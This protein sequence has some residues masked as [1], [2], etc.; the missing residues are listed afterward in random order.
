[1]LDQ[2]NALFDRSSKIGKL[3]K[4]VYDLLKEHEAAGEDGLPTSARFL[5]YELVVKQVLAKHGTQQGARRA[6]Q[7]LH[8]ALTD[9]REHGLV[10]WDWIVD[11]TRSL[12][13]HTGWSSIKAA[14]LSSAR[15]AR[16]DPWQ[17]RY[18]LVLCESRSLAGVL[19]KLA[20]RYCVRIAATNGQVGGFL[21][22]DIAP[23]L[24]PGDRVL[25]I[26]DWD[27]QGHQIE[28]N[29]RRVLERLVGGP[30]DWKRI[31]LTEQQVR[32]HRLKR[33]EIMKPDRRYRPVR[34]HPAIET[35][36]LKQQVIVGIVRAALDAELPEPLDRVLEREASQ[37]RQVERLLKAGG[38]GE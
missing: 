27:W 6:D 23:L 29:T 4:I 33:F 7:D 16:L 26:G 28:A 14:A 9:L 35:E 34:S 3:R 22:T 10:P 8:D 15:H 18:P 30:L 25:Y 5:F 21:H 36:A 31:A 17:E 11:E 38:R 20:E 19:R 12:E 13:D 24:K 1:M 32:Q 2:I 37:R